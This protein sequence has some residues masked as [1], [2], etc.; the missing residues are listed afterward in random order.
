MLINI[1]DILSDNPRTVDVMI[2]MEDSTFVG[3]YGTF[4]IPFLEP[5]HVCV[6]QIKKREFLVK[7][8][9]KIRHKIPCDRCLTDV[10]QELSL[11]VVRHI[12]LNLSAEDDGLEFDEA[13]FIR[14]HHLDLDKLFYGEI[15]AN[16]PNKTLCTDDCQG[17]CSVCGQN[18]N[19]SKC[20]CED[21]DLDSRMSVI[22]DIFQQL[23]D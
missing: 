10:E 23:G 7:A 14:G 11:A 18:L 20:S 6:E 2:P 13:N 17:I 4:L 1:S 5:V 12:N 22:R 3:I 15:L 21:T 9:A 16:W 8:E 19:I